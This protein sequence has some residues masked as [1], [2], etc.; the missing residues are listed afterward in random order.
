MKRS[1]KFQRPF[2]QS[3]MDRCF[4][5]DQEKHLVIKDAFNTPVTVYFVNGHGYYYFY[6]EIKGEFVFEL[7]L[8]F[9][10][11]AAV[12]DGLQSVPERIVAHPHFVVNPKYQK[13]G[14]I[15]QILSHYRNK[16]VLLVWAT[17][18]PEGYEFIK[19]WHKHNKLKL[20]HYSICGRVF[21]CEELKCKK[22]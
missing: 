19:R 1:I 8:H 13:Q 17:M 5:K 18:T 10:E 9:F 7:Y 14:Y 2:N 15:S 6:G 21:I 11:G 20:E 12:T 22:K 16:G 3:D 4:F